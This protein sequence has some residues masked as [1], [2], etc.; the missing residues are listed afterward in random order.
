[1]P[2][3]SMCHKPATGANAV[4]ITEREAGVEWKTAF[5]GVECFAEHTRRVY[6]DRLARE[7]AREI[8]SAINEAGVE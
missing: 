2:D 1:M 4:T 5:C 6:G 8:E 3:C 7:L